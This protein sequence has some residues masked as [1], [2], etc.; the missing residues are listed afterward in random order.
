MTRLASPLKTKEKLIE[1]MKVLLFFARVIV[2]IV[3]KHH[4]SVEFNETMYVHNIQFVVIVLLMLKPHSVPLVLEGRA[5]RIQRQ[6]KVSMH[7]QNI[8]R[9]IGFRVWDPKLYFING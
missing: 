1:K 9:K 7:K 5:G 8:L 6:G 2:K 4:A 3:P